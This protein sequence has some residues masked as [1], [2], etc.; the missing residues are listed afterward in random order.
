M[1]RDP[2]PEDFHT[3]YELRRPDGGLVAQGHDPVGMAKLCVDQVVKLYEDHAE[4]TVTITERVMLGL[5]KPVGTFK[6]E[7]FCKLVIDHCN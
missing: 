6:V 5:T 4:Y 3:L 7:E 1:R 2:K